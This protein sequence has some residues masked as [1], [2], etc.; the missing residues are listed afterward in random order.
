[1]VH[2]DGVNTLIKGGKKEIKFADF[3]REYKSPN[4]VQKSAKL[5]G[6]NLEI[7]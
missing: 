2:R 7:Q 6:P 5:S 1:M 4:F 3:L